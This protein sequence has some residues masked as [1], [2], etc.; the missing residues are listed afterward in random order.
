ME[1]EKQHKLFSKKRLQS[2]ESLKQHYENFLLISLLSI[3]IGLLEIVTRNKIASLLLVLDDEFISAQTLGYWCEKIQKHKLHNQLIN[4]EHLSFQ[5]YSS[6]N[7]KDKMRN[8]QKVTI[9]YSLFRTI[10][11][12]AF[13]FENLFKKNPNGTPRLSTCLVFGKTKC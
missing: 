5:A 7:K 4:M 6:F 8:Y 9:A 3:K 11:N 12:R 13:H 1:L 10:R 2:Y